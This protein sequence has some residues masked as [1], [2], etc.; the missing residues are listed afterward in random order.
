MGLPS[1]I[2]PALVAT[3]TRAQYDAMVASGALDDAKVE[4]LEGVIVEMSPQGTEHA[5]AIEI[6]AQLLRDAL[7]ARARVREEKPFAA[8]DDGE[9]EP[10]IAVVPPGDPFVAHP[11]RAYL[12]VEVADSSLKQDRGV[13]SA[14]YA[15]AGVPEYWVVN[16]QD[17]VVEVHLDPEG[18]RYVRTSIARRGESI[19]LASFPAVR[20]HLDRFLR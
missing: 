20:I 4:L 15:R 16:L 9:P 3:I 18:T 17:R 12:V 10:D 8:G 7:G 19:T 6:L 14:T 5:G 11:D 1:T 13:K 2:D